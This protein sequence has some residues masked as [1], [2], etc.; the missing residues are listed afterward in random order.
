MTYELFI[1]L[2]KLGVKEFNGVTIWTNP[3]GVFSGM[4]VV[5]GPDKYRGLGILNSKK[6]FEVL[7]ER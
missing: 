6:M 1:R 2:V 5:S 3:N 7:Y 4:F